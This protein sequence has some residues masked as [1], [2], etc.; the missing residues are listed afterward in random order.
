[1]SVRVT[2]VNPATQELTAQLVFRLAGN[3]AGDEVTPAT[4]MK[5]LVNNFR[6]Q[7][8]FDYPFGNGETNSRPSNASLM[9]NTK[10]DR[11]RALTT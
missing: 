2:N 11:M 6:G 9:A 4:D 7:Q 3:I 5:L 8:D 1:V 10:S